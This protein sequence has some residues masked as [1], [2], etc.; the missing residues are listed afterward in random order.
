MAPVYIL[1]KTYP[2]ARIAA[3][4]CLGLNRDEWCYLSGVER[5]L[6]LDGGSYYVHPTFWERPDAN[7]MYDVLA[8]GSRHMSPVEPATLVRG[9]AAETLV[10]AL[11]VDGVLTPHLDPAYGRMLLDLAADTGADL[12]WATARNHHAN[13][14]I[15]PEIGLPPLTVIDMTGVA[16]KRAITHWKVPPVA[17]WA[18]RRPLA[19]LDDE[20]RDA[21][22]EWA[23][24]RTD[25]GAPTLLVP[26]DDREGLNAN[27]LA[28][29][30][31]WAAMLPSTVD[32]Q[33]CI[34]PAGVRRL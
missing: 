32:D 2:L 17:A 13:E 19:W 16:P 28:L 27:H 30:R 11:D 8:L 5:L 23:A 7:E 6:G 1:A 3:E 9:Y 10:I 29:I 18:E 25:G 12:V 21:D 33:S 26:V 22:F 34:L 24:R 15:G 31:A 20:F 14:W 4:M